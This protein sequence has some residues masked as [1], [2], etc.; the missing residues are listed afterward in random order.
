MSSTSMSRWNCCEPRGSGNS[1]GS[2]SGDSWQANRRPCASV[3]TDQVSLPML[4]GAAEYTAVE[5]RETDGIPCVEDDGT[6]LSDHGCPNCRISAYTND[7]AARSTV[8]ISACECRGRPRG[9]DQGAR[10]TAF[11]PGA[12]QRAWRR[13]SRR[14]RRI[15]AAADVALQPARL[16]HPAIRRPGVRDS[17]LRDPALRHSAA[18]WRGPL[19][20]PAVRRPSRTERPTALLRRRSRAASRGWCSV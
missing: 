17:A 5:L 14:R 2:C 6:K 11:G 1:G 8:G 4:D 9:Q 19:R 18:L 10:A 15:P 20:E 7:Q 12:G 16:Q 13:A 3:T